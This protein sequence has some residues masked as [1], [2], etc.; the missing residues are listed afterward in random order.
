V[1]PLADLVKI[2]EPEVL[3]EDNKAALWLL[4][5]SLPAAKRSPATQAP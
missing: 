3:D 2:L 1:V 4:A 5:W